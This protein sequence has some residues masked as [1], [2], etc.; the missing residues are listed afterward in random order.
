MT[1]LTH[2]RKLKL[3]R[4][5][6]DLAF[7]LDDVTQAIPPQHFFTL[8]HPLREQARAV[9]E[10]LEA[11]VQLSDPEKLW[12]RLLIVRY[13]ARQIHQL[14]LS[15]LLRELINGPDH[16]QLAGGYEEVRGLVEDA[17]RRLEQPARPQRSSLVRRLATALATLLGVAWL[18]GRADWPPV[19]AQSSNGLL[20]IRQ[21]TISAAGAVL[22]NGGSLRGVAALAQPIG[23]T[24]SGTGRTL[25]GGFQPVPKPLA[26]ATRLIDVQGT[27]NDAT[28]TVT[29]NSIPATISSSTFKATGVKLFEGP[30]AITTTA[31]DPAGNRT[32]RSITVRLDTQPPARPTVAATPA[33]SA[34]ASQTLSGTKIAG[35]SVWINGNQVAALSDTLDWSATVSLTEGDNLLSIVTKDA[36]NNISTANTINLVLDN[37]PP[38]ITASP[39]A[40]TNLDWLTVAGTVDDSLTTVTVGGIQASRTGRSFEAA[41]RLNEGP[42]T[43]T[44]AATSPSGKTSTKTVSITRGTIPTITTVTPA[45]AGKLS[46]GTPASIV[47][48]AT[49][50]ESDPISYQALL[51]GAVLADWS[52]SNSATWTPADAQFGP[53]TLE[54]RSR[55]AFGGYASRQSEVFVVRK[56][57]PHP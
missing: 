21:E 12:R 42:N 45:D 34:T 25:R 30:N 50:K 35:T 28:A 40:K 37:L 29:V 16:R 27:I 8:V 51:D 14:L 31:V 52:A 10:L 26:N 46:A 48:T 15:C 19:Q 17:I 41:V 39:P 54:L 53:H 2:Y 36:A 49:D 11:S 23:G 6:E 38:V 18:L 56:P 55:D 5:A 57:V 43:V 4:H 22:D 24:A 44:I 47:I 13:S 1:M 33:W 7:R 20:S 9:A 32:T 3:W